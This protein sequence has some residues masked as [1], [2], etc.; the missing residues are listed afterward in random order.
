M[1]GE[2]LEQLEALREA[3]K[4]APPLEDLLPGI[5]VTVEVDGNTIG[6]GAVL[7]QNSRMCATASRLKTNAELNYGSID[8][9]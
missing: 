9:Q 5:P 1:S 2:Y 4:S 6:Y 8:N 3:I 7:R